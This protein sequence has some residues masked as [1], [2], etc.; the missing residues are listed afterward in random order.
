[1]PYSPG[2]PD[3]GDEDLLSVPSNGTIWS[4][5]HRFICKPRNL[6]VGLARQI[7]LKNVKPKKWVVKLNQGFSG[8]GNACFDIQMIQN[9]VYKDAS[10]CLLSGDALV[11]TIADDIEQEFPNMKFECTH[12]TWCNHNAWCGD[13]SKPSFVDQMSRLG[14]I[15]EALV[16]GSILSSPSVQAVIDPDIVIDVLST[17]EQVSNSLSSCRTFALTH[18]PRH[19]PFLMFIKVLSGQVYKGCI[20]PAAA[21]YRSVIVDYAKRIGEALTKQGVVGHFA[22]DFLA[23]KQIVDGVEK[24]TVTGIEINLR[25]GGTT[26]PY[27]T[28]CI[29]CGGHMDADG[30]F[31]TKDGKERYYE[32]TDSYIDTRLKGLTSSE[33]LQEYQTSSDPEI[34]KLRWNDNQK[35]GVVFHLLPFLEIGK[36][37]FTAIGETSEQANCLFQGVAKMM[38]KIAANLPNPRDSRD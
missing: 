29:L 4:L 35:V 2:T 36:I 19:Q 22:V 21:P 11:N 25:Q 17:H 34:V 14:V 15:A 27:S 9:K 31:R 16:E 8:K 18:C 30:I 38:S 3:Y 7:A 5:N 32:A 1:M 26:H 12:N 37:G 24:W 23:A 10:G 28:M 20:N 13:S 6:A 33:F